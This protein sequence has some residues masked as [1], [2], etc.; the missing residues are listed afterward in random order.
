MHADRGSAP[1]SRT[2]R[3]EVLA[4]RTVKFSAKCLKLV[5]RSREYCPLLVLRQ[6]PQMC[7]AAAACDDCVALIATSKAMWSPRRSTDRT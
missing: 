3:S 2:L 6:C 1:T 7:D 5:D 4:A